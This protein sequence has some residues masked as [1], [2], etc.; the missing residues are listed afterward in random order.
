MCRQPAI[1]APL[2][3]LVGPYF[4]RSAIKPG[5]SFSASS[6]SLRP[7]SARLMSLTLKGSAETGVAVGI[8][9][10]SFQA[11]SSVSSRFS[12]FDGTTTVAGEHKGRQD[13][14]RRTWPG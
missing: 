9:V 4:F 14:L 7:H 5:I 13:G 1:R 8:G 6:I 10:R 11:V 2:S 3:G 12:Y